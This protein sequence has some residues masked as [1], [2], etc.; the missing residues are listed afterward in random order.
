MENVLSH[1]YTG[2]TWQYFCENSFFTTEVL[3]TKDGD[4]EKQLLKRF[5]YNGNLLCD[6]VL[7]L[8]YVS[9]VMEL[10]NGDFCV[11]LTYLY[12]YSNEETIDRVICF[13]PKGEQRW[14]YTFPED[15]NVRLDQLLQ[16]D[17]AI[18]C[19]GELKSDN[20]GQDEELYILKLAADGAF[21]KEQI[22]GG[23]HDEH[24]SFVEI[25]QD[26]FTVYG[27]TASTDGDFPFY[28]GAIY[29]DF[30]VQV[31]NDLE[32]SG[33]EQYEHGIYGGFCGYYKGAPMRTNHPIFMP[34]E[35]DRLPEDTYNCAI[36][37]FSSG[38]VILR[39]VSIEPNIFSPTYYSSVSNYSQ[40]I[41]TYYNAFGMPV[42]QTVGKPF[43]G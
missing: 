2:E 4:T 24:I 32:L 20:N 7:P 43:I 6:V 28:A 14:Q 19:F 1:I 10:R 38:Y 18:Y 30:R 25:S 27:I 37:P 42:W 8:P 16:A 34:T 13:S 21:V 5:D 40:I 39:S 26:G 36:I 12:Q 15:R 31:S 11:A 23:S 17:D 35:K 41:A 3:E 22:A 33:A 29:E 9:S